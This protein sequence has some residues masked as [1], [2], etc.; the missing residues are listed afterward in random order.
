MND[1]IEN[2]LN[3]LISQIHYSEHKFHNKQISQDTHYEELNIFQDSTIAKIRS[4]ILNIVGDDENYKNNNQETWIKTDIR[5]ELK[6]E[7][8]SRISEEI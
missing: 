2:I 3:T 7:I 6:H 1:K 8:R 4:L 5:N